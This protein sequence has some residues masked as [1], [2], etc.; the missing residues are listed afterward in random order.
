MCVYDPII[1]CGKKAE[2]GMLYQKKAFF[3]VFFL[4]VLATQ[5]FTF[6]LQTKS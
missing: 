5:A 1:L 6:I 2:Q 3:D 4:I